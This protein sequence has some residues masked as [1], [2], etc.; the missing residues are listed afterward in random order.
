MT[1]LTACLAQREIS[2][3]LRVILTSPRKLCP[4]SAVHLRCCH[5]LFH[6]FVSVCR[7]IPCPSGH[8]CLQGAREPSGE[9]PTTLGIDCSSGVLIIAPGYWADV[10]TT[11]LDHV[12]SNTS[13]PPLYK[14]SSRACCV[15]GSVTSDEFVVPNL[16]GPGYVGDLCSGCEAGWASTGGGKCVQC[17]SKV[18]MILSLVF[19]PG[20]V[21]AIVSALVSILTHIPRQ[22]TRV[23]FSCPA[24]ISK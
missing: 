2:S 13:M 23:S 12:I 19:V 7:C 8:Y 4:S 6:G 24:L 9:C 3:R 5:A 10:S 22:K 15:G 16:C 17:H 11:P 20:A 21:L 14:C 1:P 18:L